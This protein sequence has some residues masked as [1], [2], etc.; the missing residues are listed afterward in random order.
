MN[1][2]KNVIDF[3]TLVATFK[4]GDTSININCLFN[5]QNKSTKIP[6]QKKVRIR[7]IN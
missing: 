4:W 6:K 1:K 7:D 2:K 3:M 5:R